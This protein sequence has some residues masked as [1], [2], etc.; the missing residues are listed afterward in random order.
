MQPMS[1]RAQILAR[2]TYHRLKD[3]GGY[4]TWIETIDRVI[5]HQAWLWAGAI[6]CRNPEDVF[7]RPVDDRLSDAGRILDHHACQELGELRQLMLVR[8]ALLAD[9]TLCLAY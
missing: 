1:I 7:D 6:R 8:A 4:E 5:R 3:D 9:R 2:R